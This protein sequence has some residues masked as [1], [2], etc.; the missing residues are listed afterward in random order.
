MQLLRSPKMTPQSGHC[1]TD[2]SLGFFA[3]PKSQSSLCGF[4][5]KMPCERCSSE[6][7]L[8]KV[9]KHMLHAKERNGTGS[10]VFTCLKSFV[11]FEANLKLKQVLVAL[12]KLDL[13][14]GPKRFWEPHQGALT[15]SSGKFLLNS[16]K[17]KRWK[18]MVHT[19]NHVREQHESA[20]IPTN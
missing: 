19:T 14:L 4:Q 11:T 3:R 8:H 16:C 10:H 1:I 2:M 18:K 15:G 7:K 13:L 5:S 17:F 12:V 20:M 6:L 9:S